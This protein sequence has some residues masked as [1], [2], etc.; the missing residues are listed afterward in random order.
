MKES[1]KILA[2]ANFKQ[3]TFTIRKYVNDKV[4]TKFRT[5]ALSP[6]EFQSCLHNTQNDWRHFLT[7]DDY[8]I[9]K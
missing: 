3:K 1:I 6:E 8:Y 2:K 7:T 5:N 4:S 9:V